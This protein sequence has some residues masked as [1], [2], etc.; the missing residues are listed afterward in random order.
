MWEPRCAAISRSVK[1]PLAHCGGCGRQLLRSARSF[2]KPISA[3]AQVPLAFRNFFTRWLK[4][5]VLFALIAFLLHPRFV[6]GFRFLWRIGR[7]EAKVACR[8]AC[9]FN[10]DT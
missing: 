1:A 9:A 8:P 10:F 3:P 6:V 7:H 5:V 2:L 4:H